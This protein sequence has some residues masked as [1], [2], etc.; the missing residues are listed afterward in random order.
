[1]PNAMGTVAGRLLATANKLEALM[2]F[3]F[4]CRIN[5]LKELR[6][7]QAIH[8]RARDDVGIGDA[9]PLDGADRALENLPEHTLR[10]LRPVPRPS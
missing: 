5:L 7:D 1:M 4:A 6:D 10:T 8:G 2:V 3:V 9:G